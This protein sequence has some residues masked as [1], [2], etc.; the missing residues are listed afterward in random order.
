MACHRV[1]RLALLRQ[2]MAHDCAEAVGLHCRLMHRLVTTLLQG[3]ELLVYLCEKVWML[4]LG[5]RF[6]STVCLVLLIAAA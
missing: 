1:C 2:P 5:G 3:S 4:S 6:E